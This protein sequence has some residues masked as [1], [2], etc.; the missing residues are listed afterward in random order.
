MLAFLKGKLYQKET[1][2]VII[3]VGGVGYDVKVCT[4]ISRNLPEVGKEVLLLTH[5]AV[6]EDDV[7]LYGFLKQQELEMFRL[8]LG[9][10]G[11]GPRSAL[12]FIDFL[13]GEE[14]VRAIAEERL[15]LLTKVPG[16]GKK[17]A[18]R[19][20]VDLK[21]KVGN[22]SIEEVNIKA[23][24]GG[25]EWEDALQ[26]LIALGYGI[27]EARKLLNAAVKELGESND[28]Q[29]MLQYALQLAGNMGG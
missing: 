10:S 9:V 20:V 28:S 11:I 5:M 22:I 23:D 2:R 14:L 6:R 12:A 24:N 18:Q 19:M 3:D 27:D 8:L 17:T 4:H 25:G 16:V 29:K 7:R 26:G 15:S 1:D 21:D 13:P